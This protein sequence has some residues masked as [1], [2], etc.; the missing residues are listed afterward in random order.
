MNFIVENIASI[1][2][3]LSAIGV[4]GTVFFLVR[5]LNEQNKVA[6]ANVRQNVAD[7]HQKMDLELYLDLNITL[8]YGLL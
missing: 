4:I 3:G 7:S 1:L 5:E 2:Q 8:N 6:R